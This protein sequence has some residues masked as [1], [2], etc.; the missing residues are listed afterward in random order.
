[1][2]P[3]I[4]L[5]DSVQIYTFWICMV[6][7]WFIF[8]GL[9]HH[10][11]AEKGIQKHPFGNIVGFTLS[12]FFF[13]RIVYIFSEWRNEKFIFVNVIEWWGFLHFL[14]EFFI[15]DTYKL[16]LSWAIIGFFIAFFIYSRR[17]K[18]PIEKY[19]DAL[20]PSFLIMAGIGYFG[21]LLGGQ[22]YGIPFNSLLSIHYTDKNSIVPFQNELFP[23][24]ILYSIGCAMIYLYL[25][26]IETKQRPPHWT[27]GFL[28]MGI[29][30][31][32][33]FLWE[34]LNGSSD[35]LS[36][37]FF[38]NF[39]QLIWLILILWAFLWMMKIIQK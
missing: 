5:S 23:L 13:A 35:M 24:P 20:I 30:W 9:L 39:N 34:F 12:S 31:V 17:D 37:I 2:Y 10:F 28:G 21:A 18:N 22:I 36:S 8:F 14:S 15:T 29:Y 7:A 4:N 6:L 1:M 16:S 38:I 3:L 33:I 11:V 25:K 26:R 27:T 19:I 32:M